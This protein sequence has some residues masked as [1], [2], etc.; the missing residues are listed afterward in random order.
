[1]PYHD[2]GSNDKGEQQTEQQQQNGQQQNGQQQNGQQQ[3]DQEQGGH[4]QGGQQQQTAEHDAVNPIVQINLD[5]LP[6]EWKFNF[7]GEEYLGK[8]HL[9]QDGVA[10]T[11]KIHDESSEILSRIDEKGTRK[12]INNFINE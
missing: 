9:H 7:T 8:Y 10:M 11:G 1:M 5:A 2:K 4:Q 3:G 12:R 6:G